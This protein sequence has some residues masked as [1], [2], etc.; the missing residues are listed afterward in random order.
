MINMQ[1]QGGAGKSARH[2][3]ALD[4]DEAMDAG[5]GWPT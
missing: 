1:I 3:N 5:A 2:V 4:Q